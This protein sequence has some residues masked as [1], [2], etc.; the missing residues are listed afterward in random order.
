LEPAKQ[1]LPFFFFLPSLFHF[2]SYG[3]KYIVKMVGTGEHV[4]GYHN[5]SMAHQNS[6]TKIVLLKLYR[7]PFNTEFAPQIGARFFLKI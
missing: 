4:D 7:R 1:N 6:T 5:S 3:S 2:F